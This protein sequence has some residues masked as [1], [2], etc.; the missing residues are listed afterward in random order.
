MFNDHVC[1][2]WD[3]R[4][5]YTPTSLFRSCGY[6]IVS[7]MSES[8]SNSIFSSPGPVLPNLVCKGVTT[9]SVLT[10]FSLPAT[11]V[12]CGLGAVARNASSDIIDGTSSTLSLPKPLCSSALGLTTVFVVLGGGAP[13]RREVC[14]I[15]GTGAGGVE[16]VAGSSLGAASTTTPIASICSVYVWYQLRISMISAFDKSR[17]TRNNFFTT[18]VTWR[19][20]EGARTLS[21]MRYFGGK[22]G[23][24]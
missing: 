23:T 6:A 18:T 20:H 5:V 8:S 9:S 3:I 4:D 16:G 21:K 1:T 24:A 22:A 14:R 17:D 2:V 19:C 13:V 10:C 7:S 15:I 12:T 11:A